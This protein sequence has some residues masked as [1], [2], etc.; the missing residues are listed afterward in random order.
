MGKATVI[1]HAF[2]AGELAPELGGRVDISKYPFGLKACRNFVPLKQ[3]PVLRRPGTRYVADAKSTSSGTRLVPF[4]F[5]NTQ[6]YVLEFGDR[7]IRF[8][9]QRAV[10]LNGASPH[11]RSTPYPLAYLQYLNFSQ[12][13][14]FLFVTDSTGEY[15]PRKIGRSSHLSWSL[16]VLDYGDGASLLPVILDGPYQT[17]NNTATTFTIGAGSSNVQVDASSVVG[18]N[19]GAGFSAST[20]LWRPIRF[21]NNA[22]TGWLWGVIK[23]VSNS[24]RVFIRIEGG[25][26]TS[27]TAAITRWRMGYWSD[28]SWPTLQLIHGERMYWLGSPSHPGTIWASNISDYFNMAPSNAVD[29]VV[30]DAHAFTLTLGS[31]EA[32]KIKWAEPHKR[33][34]LVG[35]DS[36][37]WVISSKDGEASITV[38]TAKA[39]PVSGIGSDTNIT[40]STKDNLYFTNRSRNRIYEF[41][42][43][44]IAG[45]Y[46]T[47]ELTLLASHLVKAG[48]K[49]IALQRNPHDVLWICTT[50][51]RLVGVTLDKQQEVAAFFEVTLGGF[52]STDSI[53]EDI[54]SIPSA[55]GDQDDLW[56]LVRKKLSGSDRRVVLYLENYSTEE[57]GVEYSFYVDYGLSYSGAPATG[58]SGLS[59][60]EGESVRILADGSAHQNKTVTG[61]SVTLDRAASEVHI[62]LGYKSYLNT[63]KI[64]AGSDDGTAQF[65]LKRIHKVWLRLLNTVGLSVGRDEDHLD[66]VIFR[67]QST[68]MN[69]AVPLFSGDKKLS[70]EDTYDSD[71][72]IYI[73]KDD[74]LPA[75]ILAIG[76][77]LHTQ[78]E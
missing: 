58:M 1:Q 76:A 21:I 18:V 9:Y 24:T 60:L 51:G 75:T 4:I 59:H 70:F 32:E 48:V 3:G 36:A 68:P 65:K 33:G 74:A 16:D 41:F 27:P 25:S 71:G 23:S 78:D 2:N 31:K 56:I 34:L 43:D 45:G 69:A 63:L 72:T 73:E 15:A 61:G 7:V 28:Q 14:D 6:S 44:D 53:V 19:N 62:G 66:E 10:L 40:S 20:D 22:G 35:T 39:D 55:V 50:D 46:G 64:E 67:T 54:G 26:G 8:F 57:D 38:P 13:G 29:G 47:R 17:E 49:R 42:F 11:E 30:T 37:S 77:Q 12:L 52:S 5:N